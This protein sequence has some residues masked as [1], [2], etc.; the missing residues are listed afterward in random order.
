MNLAAA[1]IEKR[2]VTYFFVS[3]IVVALA[4]GTA[5]LASLRCGR[6]HRLSA[7]LTALAA[8]AF[9]WLFPSHGPLRF[10]V[11][12]FHLHHA[13]PYSGD[14]PGECSHVGCRSAVPRTQ[15]SQ[16]LD[17]LLEALT[18]D[19]LHDVVERAILFSDTVHRDDIRVLKPRSRLGFELKA[20]QAPRS[21]DSHAVAQ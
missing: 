14:G 7:A 10:A 2:A 9:G 13:V 21:I 8:L 16:L 19:E 12:T 5:L 3:L 6:G 18:V 15:P 4:A 1:A 17:H 11:G 20:L